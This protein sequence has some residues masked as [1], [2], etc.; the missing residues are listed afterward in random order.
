MWYEHLIAVVVAF[1]LASILFALVA[2]NDKHKEDRYNINHYKCTCNS[3]HIITTDLNT[4]QELLEAIHKQTNNI[5]E[6]LNK[7]DNNGLN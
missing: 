5:N 3:K 6:A 4:E 2:Y 1:T 7:E